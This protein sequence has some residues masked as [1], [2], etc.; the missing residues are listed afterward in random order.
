MICVFKRTFFI[1][2]RIHLYYNNVYLCILQFSK[3]NHFQKMKRIF[4]RGLLLVILTLGMFFHL[5]AQSTQMTIYMN[6]G[7]ER[8][9]IMTENDRVYFENNETLVVEIAV[10]N[11]GLRSDRFNLADIRKITCQEVEGVSEDS[12]TS[13]CLVP[14]PVHD[15]FMLRNLNGKETLH[16]FTPDGRMVMSV[17]ASENQLIDISSLPVGLYLVKT[18]HQTLKMIKL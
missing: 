9:Y 1:L 18:E 2:K 15:A 14:N 12:Y 6:N 13:V 16:I 8:S 3:P 17:E 5:A 11:K 4:K 7:D 10:Y